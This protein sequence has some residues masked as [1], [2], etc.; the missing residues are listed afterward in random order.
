MAKEKITDF[1]TRVSGVR[2]RDMDAAV[3]FDR[4]HREVKT[5]PQAKLFV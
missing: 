2:K 3:S 5:E 1:R 4:A